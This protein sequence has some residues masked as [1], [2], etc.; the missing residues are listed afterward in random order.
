MRKATKKMWR[1]MLSMVL[2]LSMVLAPCTSAMAAPALDAEDDGVINYVVLGDS[3]TNGYCMPGYYP[4]DSSDEG[5]VRGYQVVVPNTYPDLFAKYLAKDGATVETDQLAISG[6]RAEELRFLLDEGYKGDAY[7]ADVFD[8]DNEAGEQ[9]F[10]KIFRQHDGYVKYDYANWGN[11]RVRAEYKEALT[12]A[13]V[14]SIAVGTN[15]FGTF[16]TGEIMEMVTGDSRQ[17]YLADIVKNDADLAAIIGDEALAQIDPLRAKLTAVVDEAGYPGDLATKVVDMFMYAYIGFVVNY[18]E[19][20]SIIREWNPD[21]QII[22]M[23]LLNNMAGMKLTLTEGGEPIDVDKM[24]GYVIDA[25]NL[26]MAGLDVV[27]QTTLESPAAIY[28]DLANV[29]LMVDAMAEKVDAPIDVVNDILEWKAISTLTSNIR[30]YLGAGE[31]TTEINVKFEDLGVDVTPDVMSDITE[32]VMGLAKDAIMGNV[33]ADLAD[34][35]LI[36]H[37]V[38]CAGCNSC[39]NIVIKV[40]ASGLGMGVI[41]KNV[42]EELGIPVEALIVKG[43]YLG[44]RKAIFTAAGDPAMNLSEIGTTFAGGLN[45]VLGA[46]VDPIAAEAGK[47]LAGQEFDIPTAV[48]NS[49][50]GN[51]VLRSFLHIYARFMVAEGMGIHPDAQGHGEIADAMTAAWEANVTSNDILLEELENLAEL[52]KEYG[53][54]IAKDAYTWAEKE[55]YIDELKAALADLMV[56]IEAEIE[57]IEAEVRPILEQKLADLEAELEALK[58][59]LAEKAADF[60][61][62]LADLNAK[63]EDL[64]ADLEAKKAELENAAEDAK[65]EIEKAIAEIEAM[66]EAVEKAIADAKAA[67]ETV[68]AQIEAVKA[69]IEVVKEKLAEIN[70]KVKALYEEAVELEAAIKEL[71]EITKDGVDATLEDA[72]AAIQKVL[73]KA[74]AAIVA[75]QK[76]VTAVVDLV[77]DIQAKVAVI[78]E[79]IEVVRNAVAA[80]YNYYVG[81]LEAINANIKA[82]FAAINAEILA[83]LMSVQEAVIAEAEAQI[84]AFKAELEALIATVRAEIEAK[85]AEQVAALE[86]KIAELE[87]AIAAK[88]AELENAANEVKAAIEAEIAELEAQLAAAKAELEAKIAA[89][90]AEIAA[91][92]AAVKAEI[93]AKIAE[94]EA[95]VAAVKEATSVDALKAA[96]KTAIEYLF[97]A[98]DAKALELLAALDNAVK[99][100]LADLYDVVEAETLK[101]LAALNAKV[102]EALTAVDAAILAK[103][104]ELNAAVEAQLV[105]LKDKV[106]EVNEELR[107]AYNKAYYGTVRGKYVLSEDSYY[108]SLGDSTV[109]GMG[110]EG[111][112]NYGYQTVVPESFPYKLAE[113]LEIGY[114]QLGQGGLRVEDIRYILDETYAADEYT[115]TKTLAELEEFGGGLE[116]YRKTFKEEIEKADLVTIGMGSNNFTTFVTAQVGRILAGE[117]TYEMDWSKYVT[118]AGVPYVEKALAEVRAKLA[119]EGLDITIDTASD[120]MLSFAVKEFLGSDLKL[121]VADALTKVIECYAYGY[122]GF[123]FNYTEVLNKIHEINPEALVAVVGSYNPLD[124]FSIDLLGQGT[125]SLGDYLDKLMTLV[126]FHYTAYGMLTPNTL[127]VTVPETETY[128]DAKFAG[129]ETVSIVELLSNMFSNFGEAM[130]ANANGHEYIKERISDALIVSASYN[131]FWLEETEWKFTGEEIRPNVYNKFDYVEGVDYEVSYVNNVEPGVNTAKVVVTPLKEEVVGGELTFSI[132][133]VENFTTNNKGTVVPDVENPMPEKDFDLSDARIEAMTGY[134]D[135]FDQVYSGKALKPAVKVYHGADL[136]VAGKDYTVSYKNNTKAFVFD[137]EAYDNMTAKQQKNVKIPTITIKGKGNYTGSQTIHFDILKKDLADVTCTYKNEFVYTGKTISASLSLKNGSVSLKNKTDYTVTYLKDGAPVKSIKA[138]GDY[139]I[140]VNAKGNNYVGALELPVKV[141]SSSDYKAFSKLKVST[142]SVAFGGNIEDGVVVKDG[143]T[144]LTNG[145]D[146]VLEYDEAAVVNA[147][148]HKVVVTGLGKYVGSKSVTVTI[149][150][151]SLSKATVKGL[152]KSVVY[153]G[154]EYKPNGEDLTVTLKVK[155]GK[156]TVTKTLV[157]NVDYVIAYSSNVTNKGTVKLT[158]KGIGNY[159]GSFTKSFK[160]DAYKLS[161]AIANGDVEVVVE[162]AVVFDRSGSKAGVTVL[163]KGVELVKDKDYTLSYSNTKK[164]FDYEEGMTSKKLKNA[165]KVVVKGKGNFSGSFTAY[166]DIVAKDFTDLTVIAPNVGYSTK[167]DNYKTTVTVLDEKGNKLTSGKDYKVT[168]VDE[169]GTPIPAKSKLNV[170]DKVIARI[171]AVAGKGYVGTQEVEVKIVPYKLTKLM[172]SKLSFWYTGEAIKL[173]DANGNLVADDT[174]KSKIFNRSTLSILSPSTFEALE[175]GD[176]YIILEST[177]KNN[178]KKGTASVTI[179]GINNYAGTYTVTYKIAARPTWLNIYDKLVK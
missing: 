174:I 142:K 120:D 146:Y 36:K 8:T 45:G 156:K 2:V 126:D 84:A 17:Y 133:V 157:E 100:L 137:K 50:L 121:N 20:I 136:L 101:A 66:I 128:F 134:A 27:T 114:K 108:V 102:E 24:Y 23:G 62:M 61:A 33:M 139:T 52:L 73:D 117:E 87:A 119:E 11:A 42:N 105:A 41:E 153:T 51:D 177:Y 124:G 90:E 161:T 140:L 159:T 110:L 116:N 26:Y 168:Y 77:N 122:A 29:H 95:V 179:Q 35:T 115:L 80:V 155:E 21:A 91:V 135:S 165:P 112:G 48:A 160:V 12:N 89:I 170:G 46:I 71:I 34:E 99:G 10:H 68:K 67:I 55:G 106:V 86:G 30:E 143:K 78:V 104:E 113:D 162:D 25:A 169:N 166:Y 145:V 63:L 22:L 175:L 14:I 1:A 85:Y 72:S 40:D 173:T 5:N 44:L 37:V 109:T 4:Q 70:E 164:E 16:L 82:G 6:I 28:V 59:E 74:D 97:D 19:S 56:Q 65:A 49:L 171:T 32:K 92:V 150:G 111:Y 64:K 176:D 118:A 43:A 131:E 94:I 47:M 130:H 54:G 129:V 96:L 138:A 107:E 81:A 39:P 3:M 83:G 125:V 53:P 103:V 149:S 151:I 172:I 98:A 69:E 144:T 9:W 7:T 147:G 158:F 76:A 132:K 75:T 15:N 93:E 127:Y 60:E 148:K 152:P 79:E 178:V 18:T 58:A 154:E 123:A 13:D 163:Y 167:K 31:R 141:Y 38:S 57:N 88:K